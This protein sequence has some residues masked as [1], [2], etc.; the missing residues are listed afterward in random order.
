MNNVI[1]LWQPVGFSTHIIAKKVS[2]KLNLPTSHTGTLDPMAEGVIIVLLGE[3]RR[4][5]YEYAHWLK[6]YEF[7]VVFGI[8]TDT[9]DGLGKI[10]NLKQLCKGSRGAA[11]NLSEKAIKEVL[12]T[13]VGKYSQNIPSY[14]AIKINGKPM[15]WYARNNKLSEISIPTRNGEIRSLE[16]LETKKISAQELSTNIINKISL[17][18]GDLRQKEC[19]KGWFSF[20]DSQKDSNYVLA[21]FRVVMSKGMYVRSLCV[22][23]A[24]N[25][26]TVAFTYSLVR[27]KNGE[28]SKENSKTLK[29]YFGDDYP[30]EYFN[31]LG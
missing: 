15:H 22:D 24:K 1:P 11:P 30:I 20:S 25:L 9:Y 18:S 14:A 29:E 4:K 31:S 19:T 17:V 28:Y 6:D 16:L 3:L 23:I 10:T 2:E 13:F 7:E 8:S 12:Q 26:N 27:T 5:K 21:R